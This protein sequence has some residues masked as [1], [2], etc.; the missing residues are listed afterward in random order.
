MTLQA[1][2]K[3]HLGEI[4][5]CRHRILTNADPK[6]VHD[7][8][9]EIRGLR[10]TLLVLGSDLRDL[11]NNWRD[12]LQDTSQYRDFEVLLALIDTLPSPPESVRDDIVAQKRAA[13][14][15]LVHRLSQADIPSLIQRSRITLN[16]GMRLYHPARLHRRVVKLA[17][18]FWAAIQSRTNILTP[19]A[20]AELWHQ[21]RLDIKRLRYLLEYCCNMLPDVWQN[22][23]PPLRQCQSALGDLHDIDLLIQI[24]ACT[25]QEERQ[26]A[27]RAAH[28]AIDSLMATACRL[29][30]K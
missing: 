2:F 7:L 18:R 30:L 16:K 17:L 6:A 1:R 20:P 12:L 28:T 8:R 27:M 29:I 11:R 14:A 5:R 9:V 4:S 23:L 13:Q 10:V 24:S 21:L 3:R 19:Q 22:L 15:E 25:L 26:L